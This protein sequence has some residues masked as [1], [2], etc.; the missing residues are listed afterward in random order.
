MKCDIEV[1]VTE[2]KIVAPFAGAW[3]EIRMFKKMQIIFGSLPLR[4]R[5]LKC[6]LV[7]YTAT[8]KSRSLCGSVD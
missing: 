7:R 8:G 5:G 3:I 2:T 6:L 1:S 4:E